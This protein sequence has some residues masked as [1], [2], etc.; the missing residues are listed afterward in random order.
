M[1][2]QLLTALV[3]A[4][5]EVDCF[6]AADSGSVPSALRADKSLRFVLRS[7]R[8]RYDRWYSRTDATKFLTGMPAAM[9]AQMALGRAVV[10]MHRSRRYDLV[11][12]FSH[13]ELTALRPYLSRLPPI[14]LHPEVHARGELRWHQRERALALRCG[15]LGRY[16]LAYGVLAARSR[17]QQQDMR[18]AARVIAPSRRFAELISEDYRVEASRI[19]VVPNPIDLDRFQPRRGLRAPGPVRLLFVSRLAVRKGVEMIVALSHLLADL[20]G[21]VTI[22]VIGDHSLWSDYRGLLSDLHHPIA[23][24]LGPVPGTDLPEIYRAVDGLLQPSHYEPFA[25]TVGEALAAGVCVVTSDQVG[26]SEN[27]SAA[28]CERFPAGDMAAFEAAV[29]RLV[30]QVEQGHRGHVADAARCDAMKLFGADSVARQLVAALEDVRAGA[31][32]PP[33][34]HR[35]R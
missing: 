18:L 26:A 13:P 32:P 34:D 27:V 5:I 25:L 28:C 14:V 23:T 16:A 30:G 35:G 17:V 33:G 7:S 11:Y 21:R 9:A 8:W 19:R 10:N 12:Q 20:E 31:V 22:D 15:G 3:G 29:R 2:G 1:A 4:D 24:Y 6:L